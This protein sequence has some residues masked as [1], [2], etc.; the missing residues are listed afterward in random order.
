[1]VWKATT[2]DWKGRGEAR[3]RLEERG[4][5]SMTKESRQQHTSQAVKD[6]KKVEVGVMGQKKGRDEEREG[7]Q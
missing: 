4:K 7:Q 3:V 6:D 1:M 5:G 2:K